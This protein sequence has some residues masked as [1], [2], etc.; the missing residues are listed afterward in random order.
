MTVRTS[1]PDHFPF[2]QP[3]DA[4]TA[5]RT[6][7]GANS[8]PATTEADPYEDIVAR[9]IRTPADGPAKAKPVTDPYELIVQR[10]MQ[11]PFGRPRRA[12][13]GTPHVQFCSADEDG[14]GTQTGR[15]QAGQTGESEAPADGDLHSAAR[16][17]TPRRKS[18]PTQQ[19]IEEEEKAADGT[20]RPPRKTVRT[21][22]A[23]KGR[24]ARRPAQGTV[25]A[26]R[27]SKITFVRDPNHA[28]EAE[29]KHLYGPFYVVWPKNKQMPPQYAELAKIYGRRL[30]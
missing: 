16:K 29:K 17:R 23:A 4:T 21:A 14:K 20:R 13:E 12:S 27:D 11:E 1:L 8:P 6:S 19:P 7:F 5:Y 28:S 2:N 30:Q 22:R 15:K 24:K 18:A 26:K 3:W 25:E 9:M 10:K